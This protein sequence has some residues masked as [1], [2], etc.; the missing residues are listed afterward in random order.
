M[1]RHNQPAETAPDSW[2]GAEQDPWWQW[3]REQ[4]DKTR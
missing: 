2:A 3:A 4:R 1:N